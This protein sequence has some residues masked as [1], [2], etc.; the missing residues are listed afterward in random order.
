MTENAVVNIQDQI[1]KELASVRDTVGAPSSNRISTK[2]KVFNLPNGVVHQGPMQAVILDHRNFNRYD[3]K[4]YNAQ[5]PQPPACFAIRKAISE[6]A[7]HETAPDPQHA[8]CETCPMNQWGSARV[9]KGKACANR[10]RIAIAPPD[11]GPDDEPMMLELPPKAQAGWS[12]LVNN[13]EVRGMVPVQ[14]I[15]EISFDEGQQYPLPVLRVVDTH[16][17]LELFWGLREKAQAMLDQPPA[18]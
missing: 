7:P 6:M 10:V 1:R 8:D 17:N 11:A 9:G 15:T 3:D 14:V 13:L 2:G 12:K 5:D 4:P 18:L 16:D